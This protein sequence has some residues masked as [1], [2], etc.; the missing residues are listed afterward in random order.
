[1]PDQEEPTFSIGLLSGSDWRL[2][3]LVFPLWQLGYLPGP[4]GGELLNRKDPA[5]SRVG[6]DTVRRG[7]QVDLLS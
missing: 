5:L 1:V 7:V 4:S 6:D 2:I 3:L